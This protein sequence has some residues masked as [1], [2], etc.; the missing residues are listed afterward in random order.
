ME[1]LARQMF[2][3]PLLGVRAMPPKETAG[4]VAFCAL[5]TVLGLAALVYA[6]CKAALPM[7][8]FLYFAVALAAAALV[9]P[10][11]SR[12]IPQWQ[13]MARPA[14]CNRYWL[15]P[16]LAFLATLVWMART[17]KGWRKLVPL[18]VLSMM[19]VGIVRD[20]RHPGYPNQNF[21]KQAAEFAGMAPGARMTFAIEPP[22][23][24]ME[25]VRK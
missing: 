9:F 18:L 5:V 10:L 12:T 16:M 2:L 22:G 21:S 4:Y 8:L 1:I 13:V 3:A 23:W 11:C 24:T 25:L 6:A 7:K 20:W 19:L 15:I 14:A 17:Q